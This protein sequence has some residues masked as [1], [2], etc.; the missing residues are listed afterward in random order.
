MNNIGGLYLVGGRF[1]W[2]PGS[3]QHTM[4]DNPDYV[5]FKTGEPVVEKEKYQK[6]DV[7]DGDH[8]RE[9]FKTSVTDSVEE[10]P[11]FQFRIKKS[12]LRAKTDTS[13]LKS[14]L[15]LLKHYQHSGFNPRRCIYFFYIYLGKD[16][17]RCVY[18]CA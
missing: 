11:S 7:V 12:L 17:Q 15:D 3:L 8:G 5:A 10:S 2:R 1:N 18:K 14:L 9:P 16:I 6:D 13:K 4:S